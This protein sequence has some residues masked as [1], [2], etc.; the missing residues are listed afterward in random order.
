MDSGSTL[1]LGSAQLGGDTTIGDVAGRD[2]HTYQ[3]ID[4]AD[5]LPMI[6]D[7]LGNEAQWRRADSAAREIRQQ[8]LDRRLD[9][10]TVGLVV[11]AAALIVQTLVLIAALGITTALL[12]PRLMAT[13]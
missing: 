11:V 12:W 5:L 8:Y 3:G 4:P 9:R 1:G 6:A 10:I 13:L 7:L 2:V